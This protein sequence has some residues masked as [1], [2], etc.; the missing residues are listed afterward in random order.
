[1]Q[2]ADRELLD[3]GQLLPC[4]PPT[5]AARF[6]Q[7]SHRRRAQVAAEAA[8]LR[9]GEGGTSQR[10]GH[11]RRKR[12][13]I[14]GLRMI[15]PSLSSLSTGTCNVILPSHKSYVFPLSSPSLLSLSPLLSPFLSPPQDFLEGTYF[16][17][18]IPEAHSETLKGDDEIRRVVM[19]TGKLY[20]ELLSE[21]EKKG[22]DDVAIVRVEQISHPV[23]QGGGGDGTV[24][25]RRARVG[26]GG[27]EEH[28]LLDVRAGSDDDGDADI[29]Q[30]RS[31]AGVCGAAD[32][33]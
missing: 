23:R 6:P 4:A 7:A 33:G 22:V 14:I 30:E 10:R 5:A 18:L 12:R 9:V 11:H 27:A 28:G 31:S 15:H 17:R 1:M 19:C 25:Q 26:A 24:F 2:L 32:G 16:Q 8:Q 3:P 21:R 20:Y 29:E 13:H